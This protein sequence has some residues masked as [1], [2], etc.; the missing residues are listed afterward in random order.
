LDFATALG[1]PGS[2]EKRLHTARWTHYYWAESPELSQDMQIYRT[3]SDSFWEHYTMRAL[4]EFGCSQAQ[5]KA[6][7]PEM[8]C[9]MKEIYRPEDVVLADVP[10]TLEALRSRGYRLSVVSNRSNPFSEYLQTLGLAGYFDLILSAGEVSSW[11]PNPRI[12]QSA[13]ERMVV[14]PS[15]A[16]YV[17]DNYY[18]DVIGAR[19]AGVQPI[20]LDSQGIFE[21]PGCPVITRIG[22]LPGLLDKSM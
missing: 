14:S 15:Q 17:G 2:P 13:L 22:D 18:A 20:L 8:H 6:L 10:T 7:A 16:V 19:R 21:N 3:L 11:K 4:V 5:A 12:F 1:A 9:R